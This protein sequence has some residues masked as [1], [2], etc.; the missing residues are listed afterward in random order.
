MLGETLDFKNTQQKYILSAN[1]KLFAVTDF[2]E[3]GL[4]L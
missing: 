1:R 4:T 2:F 3:E